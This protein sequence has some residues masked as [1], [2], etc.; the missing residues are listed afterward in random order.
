MAVYDKLAV[1]AGTTHTGPVSMLERDIYRS[2]LSAYDCLRGLSRRPHLT[3]LGWLRVLST[4]TSL[5]K[6]FWLP[7]RSSPSGVTILQRLLTLSI[8]YKPHSILPELEALDN[9]PSGSDRCRECSVQLLQHD[10]AA[11]ACCYHCAPFHG[12]GLA[13]GHDHFVHFRGR[14]LADHLI[15]Q[16]VAGPALDCACV[17]SNLRANIDTTCQQ[18]RRVRRLISV[19][20]CA[21]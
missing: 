12:N 13:V 17:A 1:H 2:F 5:R 16:D 18:S 9:I 10:T 7:L 19:M 15:A 21:A 14:A 6:R 11:A 3:M 8:R 4:S 20:Y